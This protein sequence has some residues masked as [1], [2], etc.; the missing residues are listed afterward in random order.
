MDTLLRI[1]LTSMDEPLI[2]T[3]APVLIGTGALLINLARIVGILFF[4]A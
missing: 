1:S 4:G 3:I 2:E